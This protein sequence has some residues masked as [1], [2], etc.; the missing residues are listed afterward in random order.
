MLQHIE[1]VIKFSKLIIVEPM[2]SAEGRHHLDK[3]H[4]RLVYGA[5]KRDS[6][7]TSREAAYKSLVTRKR[8]W[9]PR[10]VQAY[11]VCHFC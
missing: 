3:L 1:P 4:K 7:W 11:L 6:K 10:V 2:V 5:S 9:D 8:Q